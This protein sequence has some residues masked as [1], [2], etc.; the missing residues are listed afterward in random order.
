MEHQSGLKTGK[1]GENKK[2]L[3]FSSS[4]VATGLVSKNCKSTQD[5]EVTQM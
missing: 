1:G 2:G 3:G 4:K 5:E